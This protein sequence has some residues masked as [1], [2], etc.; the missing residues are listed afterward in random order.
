VSST[1]EI[2]SISVKNI[3]SAFYGLSCL[4]LPPFV[5]SVSPLS[6]FSG[7][8]A[9]RFVP[10]IPLPT[11]MLNKLNAVLAHDLQHRNPLFGPAIIQAEPDNLICTVVRTASVVL[12]TNPVVRFVR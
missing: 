3:P 9:V 5:R 10:T 6:R 11:P 4:S 1:S 2:Q 8:G 12:D 7:I